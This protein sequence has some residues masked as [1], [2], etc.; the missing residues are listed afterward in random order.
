MLK[1]AGNIKKS[2]TPLWVGVGPRHVFD[3]SAL[4][5][6]KYVF[7]MAILAFSAPKRAL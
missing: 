2:R 1:K 3:Y 5:S 6:K 4:M 7:S